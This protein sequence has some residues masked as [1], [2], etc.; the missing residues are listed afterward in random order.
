VRIY[1]GFATPEPGGRVVLVNGAELSPRHDLRNHS[2]DG[3]SW[4]Y[5]GSGPAQLA[6]AILTD[7]KGAIFALRNYQHFKAGCIAA[8]PMDEP[9]TLTGESIDLWCAEHARSPL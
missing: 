9:F 4:G 1:N 2:P 6:L 3:F 7:Y 5:C 8:L